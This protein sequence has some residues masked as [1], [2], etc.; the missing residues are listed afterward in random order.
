M[1]KKV[2]S[3]A[4]LLMLCVVL[5]V[6]AFAADIPRLTD[7]AGLLSED[8]YFALNEKLDTISEELGFDVVVV[9]LDSL[10]GVDVEEASCEI[11]DQYGFGYGVE[12]DGVI[13]LISMEERDWVITSTGFGEEAINA[14]AR[15]YMSEAFVSDLSDGDYFDAFNTFADLTQDLVT[16]ARNGEVYKKPFNPAGSLG[17]SVVISAIVSFFSVGRMK[18][19]LK[20]VSAQYAADYVKQDSLDIREANERFLYHTITSTPKQTESRS[21]GGHSHSSTSGKF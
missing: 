8:E 15:N 2:L 20:S 5:T 7:V 4:M 18:G 17:G 6:P 16:D 10:N 21:S 9:T 11:Y 13:L 19:K 14:D 12:A 3:F 1:K